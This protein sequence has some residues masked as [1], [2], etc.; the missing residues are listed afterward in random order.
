M[1]FENTGIENT[2]VDLEVVETIMRKYGLT[3]EGQ[4]DYERVTYDRK[5]VIREGTYYL[6]IFGYATT[7]DVDLHDAIIQ[8]LKPILGKHYY[9]HGIEY[10]ED[11]IFPEHLVSTCLDILTS[12][13]KELEEFEIRV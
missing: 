13:K 7:G 2:R 3:R 5:F 1:Y 8:L 10:G 6:R 4:W 11:E 9:P 12:I